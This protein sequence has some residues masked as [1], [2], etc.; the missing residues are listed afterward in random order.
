MTLFAFVE[1]ISALSL[2]LCLIQGAVCLVEPF[3]RALGLAAVSDSHT[4]RGICEIIDFV[5][6]INIYLLYLAYQNN[7]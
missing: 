4:Y 1:R 2:A 6:K 7:L 5:G 3:C